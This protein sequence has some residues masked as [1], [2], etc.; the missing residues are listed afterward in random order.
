MVNAY[1]KELLA[2]LAV[3]WRC[4]HYMEQNVKKK[5]TK[6]NQQTNAFSVNDFSTS[7]QPSISDIA[8]LFVSSVEQKR[9]FTT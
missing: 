2:V 3:P 4:W 6:K 9:N 7:G 1:V 8:D 5:N